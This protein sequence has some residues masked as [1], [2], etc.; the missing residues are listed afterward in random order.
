MGSQ[1]ARLICRLTPQ[2]IAEAGEMQGKSLDGQQLRTP[3]HHSGS[4]A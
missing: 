4:G 3:L 2:G 1:T